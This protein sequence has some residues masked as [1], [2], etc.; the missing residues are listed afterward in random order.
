MAGA[1]G[2]SRRLERLVGNER[3]IRGA[4]GLGATN[5]STLLPDRDTFVEPSTRNLGAALL[6][7]QKVSYQAVAYLKVASWRLPDTNDVSLA[8]QQVKLVMPRDTLLVAFGIK[9]EVAETSSDWD[10]TAVTFPGP[11]PAEILGSAVEDLFGASFEIPLAAGT[12]TKVKDWA[13][14]PASVPGFVVRSIQGQGVAAYR[15]GALK[16]RIVYSHLVSGA[17]VTDS[18]DTQVTSDLYLHTPLASPPTG[19]ETTLRLG[20]LNELSAPIHFNVPPFPAGASI[21]E[22]ALVLHVLA[23]SPT[24][25][26]PQTVDVEVRRIG[27]AWSEGVT[28]YDSLAASSSVLVA[29]FAFAVTG[30]ADSLVAVALPQSIVREWSDNSASNDGIVITLI[31]GNRAPEIEVG[32][33]ESGSPA[34]LRL[35]WT[36]PPPGR[37]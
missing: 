8:V 17:T 4:S 2:C 7:G 25:V 3:L 5:R 36:T 35:A 32:S 10:S 29:K 26:T 14:A 30:A 15:A 34:E 22:A 9:L 28:S 19:S 21:N 23:T 6:I 16:F 12:F 13:H 24:F 1:T 27:A 18:L 11:G 33:R 31:R 37:F 20:G